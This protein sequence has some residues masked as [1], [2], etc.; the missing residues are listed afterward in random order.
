MKHKI[1]PIDDSITMEDAMSEFNQM[2]VPIGSVLDRYQDLPDNVKGG[3]K[4]RNLG[5]IDNRL[6]KVAPNLGIEFSSDKTTERLEQV[7][8]AYDNKIAELETA[9]KGLKD[10]LTLESKAEIEKLN[11]SIKDLTALNEKLRGDLELTSK[12]K[13]TISKEFT[14]KELQIRVNS[15]RS[16]AESKFILID[17]VNT[18]DA[19]ELDKMKFNFTLDEQGNE[20]VYDETGKAVL[21]TTTAGAFA[22]YDEVL[23]NIY[24]KRNAHKKLNG[25]G[26]FQ[27]VE[28]PEE[29]IISGRTLLSKRDYSK[30]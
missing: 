16:A 18:R 8:L 11:Q 19:C 28:I 29:K 20:I 25:N 30:A 12:E 21:S 7:F 3:L 5:G 17:D 27:R 26:S 1:V 15:L 6:N 14:Q 23:S 24:T 13:E 22:K 2:Y 4:A 9:N 10:N